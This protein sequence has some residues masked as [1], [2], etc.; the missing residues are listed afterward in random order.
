MLRSGK[1]LPLIIVF[2]CLFT[3]SC[4]SKKADEAKWVGFFEIDAKIGE[5]SFSG[6]LRISLDKRES[7]IEL[8]GPFGNSIFSLKLKDGE[9]PNLDRLEGFGLEEFK[10]NLTYGII[11]DLYLAFTQSGHGRKQSLFR[12]SYVL[13]YDPTEDH[14]KVCIEKVGNRLCLTLLDQKRL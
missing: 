8:F 9:S 10:S 4:C 3:L 1:S 14:P 12:N 2:L 11:R 5:L 7:E 13:T 6:Y